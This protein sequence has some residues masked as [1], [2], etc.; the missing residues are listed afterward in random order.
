MKSCFLRNL[1]KSYVRKA[2]RGKE[3]KENDKILT[4]ETM[5]AR[6]AVLSLYQVTIVVSTYVNL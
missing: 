3:R 5:S 4:D 1:L 6:E 2:Q